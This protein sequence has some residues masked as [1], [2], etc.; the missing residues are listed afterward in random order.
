[1]P[2]TP[3]AP[4]LPPTYLGPGVPAF[5][6][7]VTG[8]MSLSPEQTNEV[9]RRLRLIYRFLRAGGS[10]PNR[11]A[12]NETLGE[13]LALLMVPHAEPK[14]PTRTKALA[15]YR[16][17]LRAWPGLG[18]VPIAIL[19]NLAPGADTIAAR[20]AMSEEFR[21]AGFHVRA[22]L[23]F[24]PEI[25]QRAST[26]AGDPK[27]SS[28]T[29]PP[30]QKVFADLVRAI[31][32]D[33]V[34]PVRLRRDP[35]I[36]PQDWLQKLEEE[37][38]DPERADERYYAAGEYL[39]VTSHLLIAVW[40]GKPGPGPGA[41]AVVE[42]RLAGPRAG[43]LPTTH[44]LRQAPGGPAFHLFL[45]RGAKE[46]ASPAL[47]VARI[48]HPYGLDDVIEPRDGIAAQGQGGWT[49]PDGDAKRRNAIAHRNHQALEA[50][51]DRLGVLS[52]IASSLV[53]FERREL[54]PN[55]EA[56]LAKYREMLTKREEPPGAD[57]EFD[58]PIR[59][60]R[61]K[62]ESSDGDEGAYSRGLRLLS[63]LLLK[64]DQ[65]SNELQRKHVA[66]LKVL[67]LLT[68]A[69]AALLHAF[70]HWHLP[71]GE[72]AHVAERAET[73]AEPKASRHPGHA[74]ED[75]GTHEE[76]SAPHAGEYASFRFWVGFVAAAFAGI[77]LL[78]YFY[79]WVQRYGE[80]HHDYRALAEAARVQFYWNVA[81][82][83][84]S[85]SANYMHRQRN[86]LDWIRAAIRS[87]V[88]PYEPWRERFSSLPRLDRVAALR[89]V[90]RCWIDGQHEY[91]R[92][93]SH[94]KHRE[95]HAWHKL[96]AVLAIAG[97]VLL[98]FCVAD[99]LTGHA[100]ERQDAVRTYLPLA[101]LASL[102]VSIAGRLA[103]GDL[104]FQARHPAN[105][106]GWWIGAVHRVIPTPAEHPGAY[107]TRW[108]RILRALLGFLAQLFGALLLAGIAY[109]VVTL[110]W[111]LWIPDATT[112]ALF[113][114]GVALLAGALAVAWAEKNLMSELAYQYNTMHSLYRDA[115]LRLR[116]DLHELERLANE[117]D[118]AEAASET[119]PEAALQTPKEIRAFDE[120][121]REIQDRLY[122]L[123]KEALDEN[124]EWL[125]LHRA[126]PLE[127][128][129][130]G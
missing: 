6:V 26:F 65:A 95:L 51:R 10:A 22:P 39:A 69:G 50:Q 124:A 99:E 109:E 75:G 36:L 116:F 57:E 73:S 100:F 92:S 64:A 41:A 40:D 121:L 127:P 86:E 53:E 77:A 18:D 68:F 96:G 31:G 107:R 102:A 44:G 85:V 42:A 110:R 81:G 17:I 38:D 52:R 29:D 72:T 94:R 113:A 126:R 80:L 84:R 118:R 14:S 63:G 47:P 117:A 62:G 23:P 55:A 3:P 13:S 93:A 130:A 7:G 28:D 11:D 119:S 48:L 56:R 27:P 43:V 61:G 76:R 91:F 97:V 12:P 9:E 120:K 33:N 19:C 4:F 101:A 114:G 105:D 125:L 24:P 89:C 5:L 58:E 128:V 45:Q 90:R 21:E 79:C 82:L 67:F 104:Q 83:G 108:S 20:L 123:G 60:M 106:K 30:R 98:C 1:M 49:E 74:T 54:F 2:S 88:F 59:R 103:I 15:A 46:H 32:S 37:R 66:W 78:V 71:H 112:R 70:A 34:F 115:S 8:H 16:A 129:M 111:P 35:L 25:Y 122:A 87:V